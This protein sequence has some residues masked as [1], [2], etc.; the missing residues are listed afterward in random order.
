MNNRTRTFIVALP[1]AFFAMT[2]AA[3]SAYSDLMHAL[4]WSQNAAN[5]SNNEAAAHYSAGAFYDTPS[6]GYN[7][8]S[9]SYGT[10]ITHGNSERR[11]STTNMSNVGLKT[12]SSGYNRGAELASFYAEQRA[13]VR[14]ERIRRETERR[15]RLIASYMERQYVTS[16]K[17]GDMAK[18]DMA[19]A[20][21]Y[22]NST[23]KPLSP[24]AVNEIISNGL[25]GNLVID[26]D[27]QQYFLPEMLLEGA[28]ETHETLEEKLK[29]MSD[30]EI[31]NLANELYYKLDNGGALSDEEL[32]FLY[33]YEL[34]MNWNGKQE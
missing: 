16:Q 10:T 24:E 22:N 7:T 30:E 19:K 14:A 34:E 23:A 25:S 33:A 21:V 2:G 8:P 5:A 3:Q 32:V 28:G 1:F 17:R 29:R 20:F 9:H 15:E 6:Y 18:A 11:R 27:G 12:G 31:E 13:A 26:D 4:Q